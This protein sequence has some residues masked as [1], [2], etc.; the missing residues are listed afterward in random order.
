MKVLVTGGS[1]FIGSHVV[2]A[3]V[4]GGHQVVVVDRQP[5]PH[6]NPAATYRHA[7][8]TDPSTWAGLLEGIEAVSHQA[9]RVG[10]GT[11]FAEVADYVTDNDL[12]TA[13]MLR[14]MADAGFTGRLVLAGS[15]VVYGEGAYHC[16]TCGPR[17]AGARHPE[18]LAAGR[19]EP[20]CPTCGG[21]LTP[22]TVG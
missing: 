20:A 3:L 1:G 4:E 8:I 9:A 5:S 15:M 14:A 13:T 12:G 17:R 6:E 10:L 11:R 19:F 7:D 21:D 22:T 2:D 18:R 16:P